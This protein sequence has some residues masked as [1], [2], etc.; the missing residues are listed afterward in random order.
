MG[1]AGVNTIK[2]ISID[3]HEQNFLEMT[4]FLKNSRSKKN[5]IF[6][7]VTAIK[8]CNYNS[9]HCGLKSEKRK[10]F[11]FKKNIDFSSNRMQNNFTKFS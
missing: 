8:L 3:Y 1:F 9:V 10:F 7:Y 2:N 6:N 5:I 11:F 4:K